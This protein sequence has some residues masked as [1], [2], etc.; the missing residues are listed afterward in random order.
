MRKKLTPDKHAI[1]RLPQLI[2][3]KIHLSL[4]LIKNQHNPL[5]PLFIYPVRQITNTIKERFCCF[6]NAGSSL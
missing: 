2:I 6:H 5:F 3:E 1:F 4:Q